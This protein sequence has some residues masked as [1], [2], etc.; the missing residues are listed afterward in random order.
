MIDKNV[1]SG[2][3]RSSGRFAAQTPRFS[4]SDLMSQSSIATGSET[5]APDV[6]FEPDLRSEQS[7][8]EVEPVSE[9]SWQRFAVPYEYPVYFTDR[10]FSSSNPV[11]AECVARLEPD[12]RHRV[13][14]FIDSGLLHSI[15]SLITDIQA[16]A[17]SHSQFLQLVAEP[18][19]LAGG[20]VIK[21][22]E[23]SI[24]LM[25]QAVADF[26]I[27][28]HSYLVAVGGG[29]FLDA[30]GLVAA[31]C[32]RGVR[33]IRVPTTVLSQ[34]DSGV[35]VKNGI[36][37]F[38]QKNYLGTFAPPFAVINDH[39]FI[40]SL[41][42]RD[43]ISGISEAVKVALIRDGQFY[44][45]LEDHADA[46]AVF[47]ENAVRYMIKRCAEL[48]MHQIARGGDPFE[49]GSARP[50]DFGHWLAHKIESLSDHQIRH[51]EAVAIGIALDTKYSEATRLIKAG[52]AERV[53]GLLEKLG[54]H[55]WHNSLE[56][57][58][59]NTHAVIDGL[60]E[61]RE[62]LGGALTITLLKDLGQ[63]VEVNQIEQ[64][65]VVQCIGWLRERLR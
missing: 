9:V 32:H 39:E 45:W 14:V 27:D 17:D 63:G 12:K 37:L 56:V 34:N 36:N 22:G 10:I 11:F 24:E 7:T 54:F 23:Q 1:P 21:A 64:E 61:F 49:S 53:C 41:P 28:R 6:S 19:V 25:R 40:R 55:L 58:D 31:T 51:G 29:A 60:N 57:T 18:I 13:L 59:G 35:G 44:L 20:E 3:A 16:Y 47:E 2:R 26:H 52:S 65:T 4:E 46:L 15:P 48:H 33:H 30:A 43:K 62:H 5:I 42:S 50:L 38:G 8:C